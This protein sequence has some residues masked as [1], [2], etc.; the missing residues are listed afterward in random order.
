MASI[1]QWSVDNTI[2]KTGDVLLKLMRAARDDD[3]QSTAIMSLEA[4][5]SSLLICPDR[6]DEATTALNNRSRLEVLQDACV[7]IGLTSGG[8]A[9]FVRKTAPQSVKAFLLATSLKTFLGDEEVSSVLH[10]MLICTGLDRKPE[11]RC[12]KNQLNKVLASLSGYTDSIIPN[13]TVQSLIQDLRNS[14][15]PTP[16]WMK[17]ALALPSPSMLA[18]IYSAVYTALL[19]DEVDLVTLTGLPGCIIVAST[20]LWLQEDNA[21]LVVDNEVL[22]PSRSAPKISIQLVT[23]DS[24]LKTPWTIQEWREATTISTLVVEDTNSPSRSPQLP[25]FAP[26]STAKA[27]LMAQYNLSETQMSQV[28]VMATAF[29]LIATERGLVTYDPSIPGATPREIPLKAICQNSYLARVSECMTCYGWEMNELN[30]VEEAVNGVKQWTE[31]GFPGIDLDKIKPPHPLTQKPIDAITWMIE[32]IMNQWCSRSG[33]MGSPVTREVAE[34]AVYIAA[35]SLF[36][37]ICSRFPQKRYFRTGKFSSIAHNGAIMTHW[38]LRHEGLRGRVDTPPPIVKFLSRAV[39]IAT[40]QQLRCDCMSSLLPGAV[41]VEYM[42]GREDLTSETVVHQRDLAHAMNGYVAWLPPLQAITTLPKKMFAV[43]V[44]SG[45]LRYTSSEGGQDYSNLLRIQADTSSH[46]Y[47]VGNEAALPATHLK[48]FDA[49]GAYLGLESFPDTE[50]L[51]MRHYWNQTGKILNLRTDMHHPVSGRVCPVDWIDSI[52]ALAGATHL[53][54]QYLP[55]FAEKAMAENW[56]M[57]NIWPSIFLI[58]AAT[59]HVPKA[60][61]DVP[62][63]CIS[64]TQGGEE[65]RFFLAGI[66]S[67]HRLY[68]CHGDVSIVKCIQTALEGEKDPSN[69]MMSWDRWPGAST[70]AEPWMDPRLADQLSNPGWFILT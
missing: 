33:A 46:E 66:A 50:G 31:Q 22:I 36:T 19:K 44:C 35:E 9:Y 2:F 65:L 41:S 30:G 42:A 10:E 39:N 48:P 59:T 18:K 60:M 1:I 27:I 57:E 52:D 49:H 69:K 38:I 70:K 40:L 14:S 25:S 32:F 28:G 23:A 56:K 37:S 6:V 11:L 29:A 21:Q 7:T 12:S 53:S 17:N 4:L 13:A 63:R 5:G 26:A 34:A 47:N 61:P 15:N 43:E 20:L 58:S 3:V 16:A 62:L 8:V 55:S 68:V 67:M 45:Y 51:R 24:D 64:R 54:N